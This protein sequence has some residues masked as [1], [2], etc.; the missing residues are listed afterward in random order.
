MQEARLINDKVSFTPNDILFSVTI[1]SNKP[2]KGVNDKGE[3]LEVDWRLTHMQ[4]A[5]NY[6]LL[7]DLNLKWSSCSLFLLHSSFISPNTH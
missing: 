2:K 7:R 1:A 3:K 6:S 4:K 5:L